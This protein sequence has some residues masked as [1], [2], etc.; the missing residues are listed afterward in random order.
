LF[1][2]KR[3]RVGQEFFK[4]LWSMFGRIDAIQTIAIDCAEEHLEAFYL[5]EQAS[6]RDRR[7]LQ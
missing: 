6:S 3:Q 7:S 2:V 1:N 4:R 5:V